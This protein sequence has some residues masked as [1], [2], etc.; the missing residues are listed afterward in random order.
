MREFRISSSISDFDCTAWNQ[1]FEGVLERYEYALATEQAGIDGFAWRYLAI[2][3]GGTILAATYGFTTRYALD[4]TLT[5]FWKKPV[6]YFKKLVPGKLSLG[7][8][9]IGSP[10]M[11]QAYLGFHPSVEAVEKPVLLAALLAGFEAMART[12]GIGLHAVKDVPEADAALWSACMQTR[13]YTRMSGLPTGELALGMDS[14]EAYLATLSKA[15]RK[16]M[17]RKLKDAMTV[18]TELHHH[19]GNLTPLLMEHYAETKTRS[20]LQF[21][22]LTARYFENVLATMGQH[23]ACFVHYADTKPVAFNLVLMDGKRMIDKFF[24]MKAEEGR[25]YHLY[26]I[27]WLRNIDYCIRH[28]IRLYQS[29]QA[30]YETK[31]RLGSQL[32]GNNMYFKHRNRLLQALLRRAAPFLEVKVPQHV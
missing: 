24:C 12:Q 8:A 23:A 15:T 13:G 1:C 10:V 29:G 28:G 25:R 17:R 6:M 30:G 18:R 19:L 2:V 20:E 26:F 27:S 7:L 11:E 31:L 9:C 4:T 16:D 32:A 22:Q 14:F 5:G 21:E 3:D